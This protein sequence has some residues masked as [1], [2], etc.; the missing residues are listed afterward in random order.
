[1]LNKMS[2]ISRLS[3]CLLLSIGAH[4]GAVFYDSMTSSVESPSVHAPVVVSLLPE[5]DI[6]SSLMTEN[7]PTLPASVLSG[8]KPP[9][10]DAEQMRTIHKPVV[11]TFE[12]PLNHLP[13]IPMV[14]VASGEPLTKVSAAE[15]VCMT[16][17]DVLQEDSQVSFDV[18]L[19]KVASIEAVR[20]ADKVFE[21]NQYSAGRDDESGLI[22]ISPID[23]SQQLAEAIPNYR[24]NPLPE[25][26]SLARQKQWQGLVWL[27]VDVSAEGLVD[28]LRIEQSCGHRLLDQAARRTV[29]HWQF[30]PAKRAGL[31]VASQVRVP[32]RFR[33]ETAENLIK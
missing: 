24:S 17:R 10:V 4:G 2:T 30:S 18:A 5:V 14:A 26:P 6:P 3:L 22:D 32:V 7:S 19:P 31:P 21:Q 12:P 28:D 23:A 25:Y 29:T 8:A 11:P 13:G 33:L 20:D 1:M 15:M 16:P 9:V 27:L